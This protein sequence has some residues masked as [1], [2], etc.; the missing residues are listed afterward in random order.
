VV[1]VPASAAAM[2]YVMGRVCGRVGFMVISVSL[3]A[4][5]MSPGRTLHFHRRA[6]P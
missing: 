4:M 3:D 1:I 6:R 2:K 5:E